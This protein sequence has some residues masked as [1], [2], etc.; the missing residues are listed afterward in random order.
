MK[1]LLLVSFFA[2]LA[3]ASVHAATTRAA[4]VAPAADV[5]VLCYHDVLEN[6][7]D[8]PI[9]VS[10]KVGPWPILTPGMDAHLYPEQYTTSTRNLA[11]QFDWLHAH[12]YH[13]VS[14]KQLVRAR[15]GHGKLPD[16]AVL[17]TFDDGLRSAYT[18]VFPLLKAYHYHAMVAVV[19][20]WADLPDNG[21]VDYGW[22]PY[23][24]E[25]FATW[26]ELREMRRSGLV[27]IASHTYDMH[28]GILANPQGNLVP[29]VVTH[30]YNAQTHQYETDEEYA[31]RIRADL[32]HS[33]E[34]IREKTGRAPRAVMWPYGSYTQ[35]SDAIAA[36]LGMPVTF[37]LGLPEGFPNWPFGKTGLEA[38]PR[39]VQ[40]SNP[41]TGDLAWSIQ[42]LYLKNNV[43]AV[44]VDLDYVYDP[45]PAQQERNL[46]VLLDR[47]K[48]LNVTQV[49]LQA[50]ADPTGSDAA[51]EVYFPNR[52]LPMRADL[53]SHAAWQLR[54]RCGV[55]VYAWMPVL[56]WH[57]PD[58]AMQA[59]LQIRPR[60]GV[61]P[62]VPVRLNPFLPETRKIVGDLYEDVA[63]DAPIAGILFH[64]DAV[65][66]DTD[67]LGHAAPPPGPERTRA[68]IEFTGE[69]KARAQRWRPQVATARNIFAEPVLHPASETW[70]AQ[71][72]PAFLSSYNEVAL[73]AMPRLENAKK[74]DPWLRKLARKVAAVPGGPNGTVFELQAED[75]RT[76]KPVPTEE[77]AHQMRLL[78]NE[79]VLHLAYYPDDFVRDHPKL[80]TLVPVFS[81]SD[82]PAMRP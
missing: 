9:Q 13:V 56:A 37:T 3:N 74:A 57:L 42:H 55:E 20:A 73:M 61:K 27:E 28:H 54:T 39:L 40:M 53:F 67:D 2:L 14:L 58:A 26:K 38:I 46:G 16:K 69:L 25:D 44:Q 17:L 75:W 23:T 66:R 82:Y 45:D 51:S 70:Y 72:L 68:L 15:T 21:T 63:R 18:Q 41:T 36:S 6:V 31:A 62:E 24:R 64:D 81:A 11:S 7:E 80:K 8:L 5:V 29:A 50:F 30:A 32:S 78:Q 22:R 71:S 52:H 43:R 34:E 19:G 12:G 59:R 76:Q 77:L 65:L 4:G 49:W 48:A 60:P 35:V 79:G 1:R 10:P 47:I 33:A